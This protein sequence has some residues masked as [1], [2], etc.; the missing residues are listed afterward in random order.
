MNPRRAWPPKTDK[1][2]ALV[3]SKGGDPLEPPQGVAA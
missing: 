1:R 3:P 2:H